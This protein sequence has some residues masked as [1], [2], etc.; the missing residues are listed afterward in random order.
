MSRS[1]DNEKISYIK[2]L[3][4]DN[5]LTEF[6]KEL[7]TCDDVKKI[8]SAVY[9]K[10]IQTN[11]IPMMEMII[12]DFSFDVKINDNDPI[13]RSSYITENYQM[14]NLLIRSGSDYDIKEIKPE[15]T[16]N[17]LLYNCCMNSEIKTIKMLLDL[18]LK[19]NMANGLLLII[20]CRYR[21]FDV[22]ELLLKNGADVNSQNDMPLV[23]AARFGRG[24]IVEL[25]LQ[26]GANVKVFST[27]TL[28][29]EK[30]DKTFNLLVSRGVDPLTLLKLFMT[31]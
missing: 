27:L 25:L 7:R 21:T 20:S 24:D 8:L 29:K 16:V 4:T 1:T 30:Y 13:V 14:M 17:K 26:W 2:S 28:K 3:I 15:G 19:A 9:Q 31:R 5:K 12:N 22:V 10:I 6:R 23:E 18:G 11:N